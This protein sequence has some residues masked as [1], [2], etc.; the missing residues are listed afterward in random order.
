MST[1]DEG[2]QLLE[3][4]RKMEGGDREYQYNN[5]SLGGRIGT[6]AATPALSSL[7]R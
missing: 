7:V 3:F 5:T 1:V 2:I 4:V 6:T